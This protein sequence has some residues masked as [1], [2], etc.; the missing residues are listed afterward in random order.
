MIMHSTVT[1]YVTTKTSQYIRY[2]VFKYLSRLQNIT[3]ELV[4]IET[5]YVQLNTVHYLC[6]DLEIGIN[7]TTIAHID[8]S[9]DKVVPVEF[10]STNG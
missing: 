6:N 3:F 9:L 5:K 2:Q 7:S 8:M 4:A 1:K 10:V